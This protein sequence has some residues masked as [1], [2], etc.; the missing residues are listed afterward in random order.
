MCYVRGFSGKT[1][2]LKQQNKT[3]MQKFKGNTVSS[4]QFSSRIGCL[5]GGWVP[6]HICDA[7]PSTAAPCPLSAPIVQTDRRYR[8]A[9]QATETISK[10]PVK[11]NPAG[12]KSKKGA[13]RDAGLQY[14]GGHRAERN[15][16]EALSKPSL[17]FKSKSVSWSARVWVDLLL[18]GFCR[19]CCDSERD[20]VLQ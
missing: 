5:R 20:S 3:K 16:R 11:G 9:P 8:K 7:E 18:R 10:M 17:T 2:V 15:L 12:E 6:V 13:Q 1:L 14:A 19:P 4:S